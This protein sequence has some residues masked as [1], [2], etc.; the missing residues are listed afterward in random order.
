MQI[1]KIQDN[2]ESVYELIYDRT[3]IYNLAKEIATNCSVRVSQKC[4]VLA[5]TMDEAK[6]RIENS[7]DIN[8]KKVYENVEDI[9]QEPV[10]DSLDYWRPGDPVT[11]SFMADKLVVPKIVNFLLDLFD[12]H[13]ANYDEFIQR[14]EITM[15]DEMKSTIDNIQAEVNKLDYDQVNLRIEMLTKLAELLKSYETLPKFDYELLSSYYDKAEELINLEL[16]QETTY[17]RKSLIPKK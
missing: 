10:N 12:N 17:Y 14:H 5:R 2:K 9:K 3:E 16:L 4:Y 6:N 11:F 7:I 8:E 15:K 13:Y 1:T